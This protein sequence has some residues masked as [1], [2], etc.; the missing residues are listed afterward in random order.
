MTK[1]DGALARAHALLER[2]P[3]VDGHNDLPYVIR[4][5]MSARGDVRAYRLDQPHAKA[6]TDIPRMRKGKLAAQF[7]AAFVP[8]NVE[9]PARFTLEQIDIAREIALA[10]PSVFLLAH[11]ADDIPRAKDA[12]RIAV[13]VTVESCVGLENSLAPLRIWH[14]AG[15]RLVTL[16]HNETLDWIDSATDRA[17]NGGLSA[18]GQR[19]VHELNRLGMMVDCAHASEAATL[20]AIACSRAPVIVSHANALALCDHPRNVSDTVMAGIKATGGI[21]MATFVPAFISQKAFDW[22]KPLQDGMGKAP[23]DFEPDVVI[24][25]HVRRRGPW[26]R[27]TLTELCDH[28]EYMANAMGTDHVGIGSDFYNGPVPR[29]LEDVS[30]FPDLFAELIRRGWSDDALA[31]LAGGNLVRVFRAAE[32]VATSLA[33]EAPAVGQLERA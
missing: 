15:V 18:F 23:P 17:R 11:S 22:V 8:T 21:V 7:F 25:L 3:L 1:D 12:G 4:T 19:V 9:R 29:G 20:Q 33:D 28:I 2:S 6:D 10:H 30:R 26:P 32:A 13:F 27:A 16:C 14:A 5:D 31:K 24:P